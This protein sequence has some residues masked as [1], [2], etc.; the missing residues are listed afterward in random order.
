MKKI[1]L[2]VA[3]SLIAFTSCMDKV[4]EPDPMQGG[5]L[6]Y[7]WCFAE[8]NSYSL[9]MGNLAF[10]LSVLLAE[11]D[12]QSISR[13]ALDDVMVTPAGATAPV[14]LK[15]RFFGGDARATITRDGDA[16]TI[17]FKVVSTA[18]RD[19]QRKGK[20][21][22]DT[23]GKLLHETGASWNITPGTSGTD[24]LVYYSD[25][26]YEAQLSLMDS[27]SS[28]YYSVRGGDG[29]IKVDFGYLNL[30]QYTELPTN[31]NGYFDFTT[32]TWDGGYETLL[33]ATFSQTVLS[34]ASG[35][36]FRMPYSS[37]ALSYQVT[38]AMNFKPSCMSSALYAPYYTSG[39][40][41]IGFT[42]YAEVN[43]TTFPASSVTCSYARTNDCK[44]VLTMNYNGLTKTYE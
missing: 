20:I 44:G 25:S 34:E 1:L 31:W 27:G 41:G 14:S 24:Q 26:G 36:C 28:L 7:T 6:L 37:N 29:R 35:T 21:T 11:A 23:G 3:A 13:D 19:F 39:G 2:L 33:T 42:T 9:D 18:G 12:A 30:C 32:G 40:F 5:V 38:S 10:R 22:F 15:E 8:Q 43:Q 4:S 16:Y 17:V